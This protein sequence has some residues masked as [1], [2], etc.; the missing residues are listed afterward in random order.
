MRAQLSPAGEGLSRHSSSASLPSLYQYGNPFAV[1]SWSGSESGSPSSWL[2]GPTLARWNGVA[3][4]LFRSRPAAVAPMPDRATMPVQA[5]AAPARAA[6]RRRVNR[7]LIKLISE[8]C[9]GG[10]RPLGTWC[11]Q[12]LGA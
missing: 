12:A 1:G 6:I 4:P 10:Q 11:D 2:I 9:R 3:V 8:R 5:T 7:V